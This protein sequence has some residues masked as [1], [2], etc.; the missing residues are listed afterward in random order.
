MLV[1]VLLYYFRICQVAEMIY[2]SIYLSL[3]LSIY[4]SM[5]EIGKIL[6]WKALGQNIQG[7]QYKSINDADNLMVLPGE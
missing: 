3:R 2:A 7:C 5:K 4:L 6:K 1:I